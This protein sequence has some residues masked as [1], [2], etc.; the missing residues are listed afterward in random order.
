MAECH[1]NCIIECRPM[2]AD[3][4]IHPTPSVEREGRAIESC[5]RHSEQLQRLIEADHAPL[6]QTS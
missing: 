5:A 4:V 3:A 6:D 2:A 1:D